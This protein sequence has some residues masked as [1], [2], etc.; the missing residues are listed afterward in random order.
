MGIL[1]YQDTLVL[2]HEGIQSNKISHR[3]QPSA[4]LSYEGNLNLFLVRQI[5]ALPGKSHINL[6]ATHVIYLDGQE[7]TGGNVET[8]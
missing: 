4:R 3:E 5:W 1:T 6:P 8:R 7:E 2:W